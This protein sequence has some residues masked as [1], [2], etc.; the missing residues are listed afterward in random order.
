MPKYAGH[1]D[2]EE[3][4]DEDENQQQDGKLQRRGYQ[5]VG[6]LPSVIY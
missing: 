2:G 5:D 6:Q 3:D 4:E 1:H